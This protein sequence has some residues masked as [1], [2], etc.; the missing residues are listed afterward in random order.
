MQVNQ[1]IK[2][3]PSRRILPETYKV[4][5]RSGNGRLWELH[6]PVEVPDA[7]R[8]ELLARDGVRGSEVAKQAQRAVTRDLPDAEE[9]QDVVY[10]VRMEVPGTSSNLSASLSALYCQKSLHR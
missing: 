8:L 6:A 10:A 3:K 2:T 1:A 9:A 5:L 4:L 7:M